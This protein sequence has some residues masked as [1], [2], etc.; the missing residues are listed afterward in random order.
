MGT[1][2]YPSQRGHTAWQPLGRKT[3]QGSRCS[4]AQR[5]VSLGQ[6]WQVGSGKNHPMCL[7]RRP[8]QPGLANILSLQ[9]FS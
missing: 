9:L 7:L 2:I 8:T 3:A 4:T 5:E 1:G 6:D